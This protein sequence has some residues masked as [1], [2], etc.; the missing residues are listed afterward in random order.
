MLLDVIFAILLVFAV[1]KGFQ[2][3][4]I[5]GV[6]SFVAVIVGLAAA[7]KLSAVVAGYLGETVNVSKQWLPFLSFLLVFIV[8]VL[9]IRLGA[10]L[11]QAS[12]EAVMLGW[13]NRLGGILFY[14]AIYTIVYSIILF[15]AI[16]LKLLQPET[17]ENSTVYSVIATWGPGIMDAIGAVI[18][19]FKNM[20][21]ELENFF[22]SGAQH[23]QQQ[24]PA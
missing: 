9:L 8:V 18:P 24:T 16:Q 4:L 20:F 1:I 3:G 21:I 23:I 22:E 6:F 13:A 10:N 5:V 2:R 14:V 7:I 11:L 19:F 17:A 15:Y 12:V